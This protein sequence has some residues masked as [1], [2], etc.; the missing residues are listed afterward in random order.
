LAVDAHQRS[1]TSAWQ[2][3]PPQLQQRRQM[4][5][6]GKRVLVATTTSP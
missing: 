1:M 4:M 3:S 6:P 2:Q 5:T